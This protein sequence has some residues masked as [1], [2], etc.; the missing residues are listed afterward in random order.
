LSNIEILYNNIIEQIGESEAELRK[1]L[2]SFHIDYFIFK[3]DLVSFARLFATMTND[4][5]LIGECVDDQ[6]ISRAYE[7]CMIF[8]G[9]K[10]DSKL[11]AAS[12]SSEAESKA[13]CFRKIK[14]A[15]SNIGNYLVEHMDTTISTQSGIFAL[16]TFL[17]VIGEIDQLEQPTQQPQSKKVANTN[18][19]G[20]HG[21][22][23]TVEF[24]V[25]NSSIKR[26]PVEWKLEKFI[27]KMAG[28][29]GD[30]NL[31]GIALYSLKVQTSFMSR[32][33]TGCCFDRNRPCG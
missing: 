25:K 4:A 33:F 1:C 7:A 23:P 10:C 12:E 17:K 18:K 22:Q 24:S 20:A 14:H 8:A 21:R 32:E 2:T 19:F 5:R 15:M 26:L 9:E 31:L 3:S 27:K 28:A 13:D 11:L 29:L 16:R 6:R 30:V